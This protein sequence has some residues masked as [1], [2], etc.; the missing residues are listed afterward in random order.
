L[1]VAS[2]TGGMST[3][4]AAT[5]SAAGVA[6]NGAGARAGTG[7]ENLPGRK[8]RLNSWIASTDDEKED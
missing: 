6:R 2:A 3:A 7:S 1:S 8:E 4:A 5:R